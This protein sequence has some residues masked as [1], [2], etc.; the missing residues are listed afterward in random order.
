MTREEREADNLKRLALA[1]WGFLNLRGERIAR[2]DIAIDG[3][4]VAY[5]WPDEDGDP[6]RQVAISFGPL[7]KGGGQ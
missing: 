3:E 4:T 5:A 1:A 2:V 7:V 6:R